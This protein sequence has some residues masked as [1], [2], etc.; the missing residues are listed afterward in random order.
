MQDAQSS[1]ERDIANLTY[2]NSYNKKKKNKD[3]RL[4]EFNSVQYFP[5]LAKMHFRKSGN[6]VEEHNN[7]QRSN[8]SDNQNL[9]VSPRKPSSPKNNNNVSPKSTFNINSSFTVKHSQP[10]FPS[11]PSKAKKLTEG[12]LI[13]V[14]ASSPYIPKHKIGIVP[15]A[16]K[17]NKFLGG[18]FK[19]SSKTNKKG[20]RV[21]DLFLNSGDLYTKMMQRDSLKKKAKRNL[22]KLNNRQKEMLKSGILDVPTNASM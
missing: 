16:E 7:H 18:D 22:E 15:L 12:T 3:K 10:F 1:E 9:H 20:C 2:N 5:V 19:P 21:E 8:L 13:S 4:E 14:N 17:K 6:I 11:S